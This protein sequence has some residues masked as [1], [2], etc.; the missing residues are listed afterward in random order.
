MSTG[1]LALFEGKQKELDAL[2]AKD[3]LTPEELSRVE[4]LDGELD[5]LQKEIETLQAL[6]RKAAGRAA[7]LDRPVNVLAPVTDAAATGL[8]TKQF[9]VPAAALG[10]GVRHF[11]ARDCDVLG[12]HVSAEERAYRF[13]MWVVSSLLGN[14]RAN[15]YCKDYGIQTKIAAG[16][17]LT[18]G[19]ALIPDEFSADLIRLREMYG[20]FRA[21]CRATRMVRDT[22]IVPRMTGDVTAHYIAEGTAPAESDAAWDNVQLVSKKLAILTGMTSEI[23]EESIIDVADALAQSISYSLALKEDQ[24]AFNGDGT[25]TYGGITGARAKLLGLSATRA[26]IAGLVVGSGN[27]FSELTLADFEKVAG[28]LPAYAANAANRP[29]WFVSRQFYYDVMLRLLLAQGGA[30]A[31]EAMNL[32]G[33][34]TFLTYPVVE[35]QVMPAVDANDQVCALF[36]VPSLAA[37]LGDRREETLALSEHYQFNKDVISVRATM[38]HDIVWHDV[39]NASGTAADRVPGPIVGLLTAAS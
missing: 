9:T 18:A 6:E 31:N 20:V 32:G 26:N 4:A 16:N 11:K 30:T 13:G 1:T 17:S 23:T 5:T 14:D 34:R 12:R 39:G 19:S 2:L 15:R 33:G 22:M 27:L 10:S 24:S 25:S 21:N 29:S 36:G 28:R 35:A 37:K 3:G 8:I 7:F 38:L